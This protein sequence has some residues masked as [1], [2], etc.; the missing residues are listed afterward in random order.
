MNT[1][2]KGKFAQS[3]QLIPELLT[4]M[5]ALDFY[6]Q[7][8][9][10][11]LGREWVEKQF[12]SQVNHYPLADFQHTF[13]HHVAQQLAASIHKPDA[14]V[15]LTGGGAFN[16]FLVGLLKKSLPTA[17]IIIPENS[18]ISF[19]EAIIFG[20]L[21]L[22]GVLGQAHCAY[23]LLL[24]PRKTPFQCAFMATFH[25]AIFLNSKPCKYL[26]SS[27]FVSCKNLREHEISC[28]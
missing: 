17:Q 19:K 14:S 10:K 6:T 23:R 21:G 22:F 27:I 7:P 3:G 24:V 18:I 20:F 11:S 4:L 28:H 5:N 8:A 9:P 15:L 1:M 26:G 2:M 25:Q 13:A 12:I 16:I